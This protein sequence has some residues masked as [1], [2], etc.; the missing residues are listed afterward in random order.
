MLDLDPSDTAVMSMREIKYTVLNSIPFRCRTDQYPSKPV[1]KQKTLH[2][3]VDAR[4]LCPNGE[5]TIPSV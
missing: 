4:G 2:N 5:S 1:G 3:T